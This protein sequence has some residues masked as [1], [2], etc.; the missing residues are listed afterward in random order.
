MPKEIFGLV[1]L[2]LII[3]F[4]SGCYLYIKDGDL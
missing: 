2:L 3:A 1:I 4:A